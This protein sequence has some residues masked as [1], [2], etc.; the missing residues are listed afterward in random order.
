[1]KRLISLLALGVALIVTSVGASAD[2]SPTRH[3]RFDLTS[4]DSGSCGDVWAIDSFRMDFSVRQVGPTSFAL[5]RRS[6][7]TFVSTGPVSPG[8]CDPG[9]KHGFVLRAGVN[10]HLES[11]VKLIVHST[12]FNPDVT[13]GNP[14]EC[15][16]RLF[17]EGVTGV[18]FVSFAAHYAAGDQGLIYHEWFQGVDLPDDRGDIASPSL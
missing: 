3:F 16:D 17:G 8:A 15:F 13:C 10:G 4:A 14:N 9:T 6:I 12:V 1:M 11:D 7:G 18:D 5:D 2:G